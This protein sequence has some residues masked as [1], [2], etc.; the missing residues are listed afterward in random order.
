ME[1]M[2]KAEVKTAELMVKDGTTLFNQFGIWSCILGVV[3]IGMLIVA[4]G[5]NFT[6]RWE[7]V[8][9][10]CVAG[11]AICLVFWYSAAKIVAENQAKIDKNDSSKGE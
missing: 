3:A 6:R 10:V 8:F 4:G 2:T 9:W 11:C 5:Y 1:K 7:I